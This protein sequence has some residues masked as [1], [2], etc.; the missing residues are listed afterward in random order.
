M[1]VM[2]NIHE[3]DSITGFFLHVKCWC[4]MFCVRL[5]FEIFILQVAYFG[6]N[7]LWHIFSLYLWIRFEYIV[8]RLISCHLHQNL[9]K[10]I[11]D[12]PYCAIHLI[13]FENRKRFLSSFFT[14][15]QI[16]SYNVVTTKGKIWNLWQ[17]YK[18]N[19]HMIEIFNIF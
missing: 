6:R 15:W 5:F 16:Y 9:G 4:W 13:L 14:K 1:T 8:W 10:N 11:Y 7:I 19:F 18:K 17:F 3:W 2:Y 12:I